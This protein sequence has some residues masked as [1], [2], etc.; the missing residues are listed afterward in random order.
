MCKLSKMHKLKSAKYT[1]A[2]ILS[3]LSIQIDLSLGGKFTKVDAYSSS[4]RGDVGSSVQMLKELDIRNE[5]IFNDTLAFDNQI[6][7]G[8]INKITDLRTRKSVSNIY[9]SFDDFDFVKQ[10]S[11]KNKYA[12]M[13]LNNEIQVFLVSHYSVSSPT[14]SVAVRAGSLMEDDKFPGVASLLSEV[15]FNN[16][17]RK[18]ENPGNSP[19]DKYISNN[20]GRF[21]IK[22]GSFRTEY[23]LTIKPEH[24]EEALM[25]FGRTFKSPN[26]NRMYLEAS[27]NELESNFEY[28][29]KDQNE[30]LRQVLRDISNKEHANNGFHFA[31][32]EILKKNSNN[33]DEYLIF[34]LVKFHNTYYSSNM[35]SIFI[36]SD[37]NIEE[38]KNYAKIYFEDI[39]NLKSELITPF[40]LS[41]NVEHPYLVLRQKIIQIKSFSETPHLT[42]MFPI[43]YQTVFW[44][45]K[46]A[47][48][49]SSFLTNYSTNSLFGYLKK[50]G[51]IDDME[52]GVEIND[53]GFSNYIIKY[54]L[55]NKGD[56]NIVRIME[57]TLSFIK[58]IKEVPI[59][60]AIINQIRTKR[61]SLLEKR[62][63]NDIVNNNSNAHNPGYSHVE[64]LS[65][66]L[67][68]SYLTNICSPIDVL[69]A[70]TCMSKIDFRYVVNLLDYIDYDNMIVLF[71]KKEFKKSGFD[72]LISNSDYY[73]GRLKRFKNSFSNFF[74]SIKS[75]FNNSVIGVYP[76]Y[77]TN[78]YFGTK[79]TLENIPPSVII[80]LS[81]LNT[82]LAHE[83]GKLEIPKLDP[84][85]PEN[86][87][88]YTEGIKL[89]E[90]PFNL[91]SK[92][93][94]INIEGSVSGNDTKL[95][96]SIH[97]LEPSVE[98]GDL[99][100]TFNSSKL[101]YFTKKV[102]YFP[103]KF[104]SD[105]LVHTKL[106]LPENIPKDML[107]YPF[108]KTIERLTITFY[109]YQYC[110]NKFLQ[111]T[112]LKSIFSF[113][114]DYTL[115]ELQEFF[116]GLEF[117]WKGFTA[118]FPDVINEISETLIDLE[119]HIKQSLLI[120]AKN[121]FKSIINGFRSENENLRIIAISYELLDPGFLG[122]DK[123]GNELQ[124]I[125]LQTII[126][127][128]RFFS[129][130]F[131]LSSSVFGNVNPIQ[132]KYYLTKFIRTTRQMPPD[133][134]PNR[135]EDHTLVFNVEDNSTESDL[136]ENAM[137]DV[138][139][140]LISD[141]N[142]SLYE[143]D[144]NEF[145]KLRSTN[146]GARV[147]NN[148]SNRESKQNLSSEKNNV[149]TIV[150]TNNTSTSVLTENLIKSGAN[151]N[152]T[153]YLS[154]GNNKRMNNLENRIYIRN[155]SYNDINRLPYNYSSSYFY[156]KNKD[157]RSRLN[158]VLL[159]IYIGYYS[160]SNYAML[161]V[162]SELNSY[163][164]FLEYSK[165]KC[166]DCSLTILPRIILSKYIVLEFKVQSLIKNVKELSELL[167]SFYQ[168]YYSRPT[169]MISKSQVQRA[170][171][172]IES[173][174][175]NRLSGSESIVNSDFVSDLNSSED[176]YS[177]SHY[178][179]SILRHF[180]TPCDWRKYYNQFLFTL[181]YDKFFTFWKYLRTSSRIMISHQSQYNNSELSEYI[182]SYVPHG[183]TK[184]FS[185]NGLY[186]IN[187]QQLNY[188]S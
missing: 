41:G 96:S 32:R 188:S 7:I 179:L 152:T 22:V 93:K 97:H 145:R 78:D 158:I 182:E 165:N 59:S 150:S 12:F 6:S 45:F 44:K 2:L 39:P 177:I 121:K 80:K 28:I 162:L 183:Y 13:T 133:S 60:E 9:E 122:I 168:E 129:S 175:T 4:Q 64:E 151:V 85:Y 106:Y 83:I 92:L 19:Y 33:D 131:A 81:G 141:R 10:S 156:Y 54:T 171:N 30:R 139:L 1:L 164:F 144:K 178:H 14:I 16:W 176:L 100:V 142:S 63:V 69:R 111:S 155:S 132:T 58:L 17:K 87:Q 53:G 115:W 15:M 135:L 108:N 27:F 48:Y 186:E 34:Q 117:S 65:R 40:Y 26:L 36:V 166:S 11:D 72:L 3:L 180:Q 57:M 35:I 147:Y 187:E 160:E 66:V 119:K 125:D 70:L 148:K 49:I 134:F 126:K 137:K 159:Q 102:C 71:E 76:N 104:G 52:A 170:I 56:K 67:L 157:K 112:N 94:E 124:N 107:N 110:L 88:I 184:I 174:S 95:L 169:K 181:T 136:H 84:N 37:K 140:T 91:Y 123:L 143:D 47:E 90:Y 74:R 167:N 61:Q 42:L 118:V 24:F 73:D 99:Y 5:D 8:I 89:S 38:L 43:P 18:S 86:F 23:H 20:K 161:Q 172:F 21:E 55:C 77:L 68:D 120:E 114:E 79:Y 154:Q 101:T 46:P 31:L 130:N 103:T 146:N 116:Y 153:I 109:I 51:Y 173:I 29:K 127:F 98:L 128:S 105:V 62:I 163:K 185:I 113:K 25:D 82:T 149:T 138:N 75:R 50:S